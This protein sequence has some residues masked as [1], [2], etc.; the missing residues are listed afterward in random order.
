M[1]S[2]VKYRSRALEGK[3]IAFSVSYQ[4]DNMLERGMGFEHLRELLIRLAR[5][6][7]RHCASLAYG[8]H[9]K[10]TEDNFMFPLLRLV[11]AE[12]EDVQFKSS[13]DQ[14]GEI[15]TLYNHSPWPGYLDITPKIEAQWINSCRIIRIT[16][17]L[18]GIPDSEV[19]PDARADRADPRTNLNA[20]ITL[21]AMRRKM[22]EPMEIE[23]P[24]A[25]NEFIPPVSARILLGGKVD[26]Y[27]GFL[28]G[29]FEEAL[30]TVRKGCPLYI[31]GGF[32]GAAEV[33]A[34]AMLASGTSRPKELTLEWHLSRNPALVKLIESVPRFEAPRY[35][36]RIE[37][38]FN[39]LFGFVLK[40]RNDPVATLQTGLSKRDT[41]EL[42]KT[43]EVATAVH[44][45]RTGLQGERPPELPA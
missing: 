20:A 2:I 23:I 14:S 13:S 10:E 45:V 41:R 32:G 17:Q 39:E 15:G 4:R 38:S 25:D 12:K 9:W 42:L 6:M 43:S 35:H 26:G 1:S 3:V 19:V 16:Q 29:I 22:M 31:L 24:G 5:P 40:A 34:D 30:E 36:A 37:N 44:L 18:A 11:S 27:S 33:L 21:S 28:P 7:L 8:G